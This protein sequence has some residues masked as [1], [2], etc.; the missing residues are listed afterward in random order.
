MT[1]NQALKKVHQEYIDYPDRG[2]LKVKFI[3]D[4]IEEIYDDQIKEDQ[5][6]MEL[7]NTATKQINDLA[8]I[9]GAKQE[10]ER[11]ENE[12]ETKVL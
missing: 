9:T 7:I 1:K 5:K 11:D 12:N 6:I 3:K 10:K 8:E 4:L 2:R